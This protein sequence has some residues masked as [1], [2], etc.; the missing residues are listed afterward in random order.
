V[1]TKRPIRV[2]FFILKTTHTTNK[3]INR[4]STW[5]PTGKTSPLLKILH[6]FQKI[7]SPGVGL[8]YEILS[9]AGKMVEQS[10]IEATAQERNITKSA[11]KRAKKVWESSL[12]LSA[13]LVKGIGS[14]RYRKTRRI[15]IIPKRVIVIST[16]L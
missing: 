12:C 15:R 6:L 4:L 7:F 2:Y 3:R 13:N 1:N 9:P 16:R 10:N 5:N 11:L 14:G 8:I